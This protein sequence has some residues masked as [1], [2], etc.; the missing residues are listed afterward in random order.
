MLEA[1]EQLHGVKFGLEIL[2]FTLVFLLELLEK[3]DE[4][5][6]RSLDLLIEHFSALLQV[7]ANVA[8]SILARGFSH[9][10]LK[11]VWTTDT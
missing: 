2:N 11:P 5:V 6:L 9:A 3:P 8:H 10:L 7:P 1:H 4:L